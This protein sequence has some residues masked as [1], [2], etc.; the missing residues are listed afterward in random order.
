VTKYSTIRVVGLCHQ[1]QHGYGMAGFLLADRFGLAVPEIVR[2]NRDAQDRA[3]KDA[4]NALARQAESFIDIKA[5]G[6]NHFTWM[7]DV[8]DRRTGQ[9]LYPELRARFLD[10]PAQF[11]PL[12][13]DMIRLTG[14]V[15]VPGD[16]HLCEY[17]P[18]THNP[19]T[20][21]WE[22][23]NLP[24]YQWDAGARRRDDLWEQIARLGDSDGPTLDGLRDAHSEGIFEVIYGVGGDAAIYRDAINVQ[25]DGA[26]A[27][28]PTYSIVEAPGILSGAGALPLR[29]GALPPVAAEL[30]RREA[31]RVELVVD[32]AVQG[33]R[34]LALQALALDPTV[35]DLDLARAI[36]DDYLAEY[37]VQLPQ[38]H[39]NWRFDPL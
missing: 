3:Y 18:Y 15:P 26:M 9:D 4:F 22:R 36:L 11:E 23:Y 17:L 37:R 27:N 6:L 24:L 5:A 38:F 21:P 12:T 28:L 14:M 2:A 25:N 34:E 19:V 39:G 33:D 8:R 29:M 31:E 20:K 16:A 7:L 13:R 10:G 35:D 1:V 32:A 30:C